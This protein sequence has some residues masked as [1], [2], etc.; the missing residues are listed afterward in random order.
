[1]KVNNK[2]NLPFL[3]VIYDSLKYLK[4]D[5][6]SLA[7]FRIILGLSIIYN[8]IVVKWNFTAVLLGSSPVMPLEEIHAIANS[9]A[10]SVFDFIN[11][12]TF[13]RLYLILYLITA[14]AFTVG[15][16]TRISAVLSVF[17]QFNLFQAVSPFTLGFDMINF[18][19]SFWAMFLPLNNFFSVDKMVNREK[20]KYQ[21]A[22]LSV[23]I[24]LL[25]Q[26][27]C[28]YFFTGIFKYD[29]SWQE[30]YAVR[31]ML[32]DDTHTYGL[33]TFFK[34][35]LLIYQF[36]TFSTLLME[37]LLIFLIF[38]P[39]KNNWMR[40][41][42]SVLLFLFHFSILLSYDA[43]NFSITGIA[44]AALLIPENVWNK[45]M[46]SVREF[47]SQDTFLIKNL[48]IKKLLAAFC[49]FVI[50]VIAE[51]NV[52]NYYYYRKDYIVVNR[53]KYFHIPEPAVASF[54]SQYWRMF[55]PKPQEDIGWL[56]ICNSTAAENN[57]SFDCNII[58]STKKE[59]KMADWETFLVGVSRSKLKR[60]QDQ[61][62]NAY[63]IFF[64]YWL[65]WKLNTIENKELT[66]YSPYFLIEERKLCGDQSTPYEPKVVQ[67]YYAVN[68]LIARKIYQLN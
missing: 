16:Q 59:K 2:P 40:L 7:F 41:S 30:G 20:I 63:F 18:Q 37:Y 31:N 47:N 21:E 60:G 32:L 25:F 68:D 39:Y 24:A 15:Y 64:S 43:G 56:E 44:I 45:W 27:G 57:T 36:L 28:I 17:F 19:L 51:R 50:F 9:P 54:F 26:V 48:R 53:L 46:I 14:I 33:A 29:D 8:I 5:T 22:S 6:R 67:Y 11:S 4:L 23:C 58:F 61:Q 42:A 34:N 12:D 3:D 35:N 10:F 65:K 49:V 13:V 52:Y 1:M 38:I 55:A 62:D 66:N